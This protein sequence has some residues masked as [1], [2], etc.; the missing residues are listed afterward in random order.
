VTLGAAPA[1]GSLFAGWAGACSGTAATCTLTLSGTTGVVAT[2]TKT[3]APT[4]PSF[5][6]PRIAGDSKA[7]RMI[8]DRLRLSPNRRSLRLRVTCPA[9][10]PNNCSGFVALRARVR[11]RTLDFGEE[12]FVGMKGGAGRTL[13]FPVGRRAR[14]A[15]ARVRTVR[16]SVVGR[17]RDDAFNYATT[18]RTVALRLRSPRR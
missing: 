2:F 18:K 15:L 3:A 7:P 10:E 14:A 12:A 16:V 1:P 5:D 6:G 11:G 8:V 4:G 17:A 13:T 9:S